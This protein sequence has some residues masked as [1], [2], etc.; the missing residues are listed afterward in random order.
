MDYGKKRISELMCIAHE[1]GIKY[2]EQMK[3]G[4]LTEMLEANDEDSSVVNDP[5]FDKKCREHNI[6]WKKNNP[7]RLQHYR[8]KFRE[9]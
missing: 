5:E 7:E 3:K 9:D 2:C 8:D 4:K 1:R 6:E